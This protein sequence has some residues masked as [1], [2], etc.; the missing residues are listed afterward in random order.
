MPKRCLAVNA[1]N[2]KRTR[3]WLF[4]SVPLIL[5][6]TVSGNCAFCDNESVTVQIVLHAEWC[7]FHSLLAVC[8][9]RKSSFQLFIGLERWLS[10]VIMQLRS[11]T[12]VQWANSVKHLPSAFEVNR[13]W[14]RSSVMCWYQWNA[15]IL[16]MLCASL[17]RYWFMCSTSCCKRAIRSTIT[18][19]SQIHCQQTVRNL[20]HSESWLIFDKCVIFMELN[21]AWLLPRLRSQN[22]LLMH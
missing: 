4:N 19:R 9:S 5:S 14:L 18:P 1:N 3:Y 6:M 17:H 11:I 7:A 8:Q 13:L 12:N 21:H 2:G 20:S 15:P 22:V 10:C 16:S